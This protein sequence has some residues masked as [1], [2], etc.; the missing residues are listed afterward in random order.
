[1]KKGLLLI[2]TT[3][4]SIL[5]GIQTLQQIE[6]KRVQLP[7]GWSLTPIDKNLPLGTSKGIGLKS[8]FNRAKLIGAV[9]V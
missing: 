2:I 8:M 7:N 5:G 4:L 1:M 3:L 6:S 9:I